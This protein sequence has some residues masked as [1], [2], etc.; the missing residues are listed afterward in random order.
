EQTMIGG[1]LIWDIAEFSYYSS[2]LTMNASGV[3]KIIRSFLDGYLESGSLNV[4]AAAA[5]TKYLK[6]FRPFIAPRIASLVRK[7]L[8]LIR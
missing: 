6:P 4:V 3:K 7:E 1:D 2:R 8:Q 5:N